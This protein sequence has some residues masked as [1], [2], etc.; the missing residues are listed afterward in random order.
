M[1]L[2]E[3]V[4]RKDKYLLFSLSLSQFLVVYS[5]FRLAAKHSGSLATCLIYKAA[6]VHNPANFMLSNLLQRLLTV[7]QFQQILGMHFHFLFL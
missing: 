3:E 4:A 1:I 2:I 6:F 7:A 5:Y